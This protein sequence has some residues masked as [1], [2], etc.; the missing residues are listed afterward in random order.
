MY[1]IQYINVLFYIFLQGDGGL[2]EVPL[3]DEAGLRPPTGEES[4]SELPEGK[5]I[6]GK[7]GISVSNLTFLV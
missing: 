3:Q 6:N 5:F 1:I 7:L 2:R 4:E